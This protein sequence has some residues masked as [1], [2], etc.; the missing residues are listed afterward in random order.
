MTC[1]DERRIESR[2]VVAAQVEDRIVIQLELARLIA[3]TQSETRL[4]LD[5]F[6]RLQLHWLQE[7]ALTARLQA[8]A[9]ELL[10]DV[11]R[12]TAMAGTSGAPTFHRVIGQHAHVIPRALA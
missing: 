4:C 3:S 7:S 8:S 5:D 6:A 12:R 2:G 9:T 10:G 1:E 11:L